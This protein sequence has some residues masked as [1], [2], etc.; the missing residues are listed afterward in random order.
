MKEL[1]LLG[2]IGCVLA[3]AVADELPVGSES[4]SVDGAATRDSEENT[5]PNTEVNDEQK[6]RESRLI[7]LYSSSTQAVFVTY[8]TSALSTCFSATNTACKKRRKR[9]VGNSVIDGDID[10]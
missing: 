4:V 8:T 3:A 7:A 9:A 5:N 6:D 2:V 1:V 10:R